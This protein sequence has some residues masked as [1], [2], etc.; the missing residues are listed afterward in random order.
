MEPINNEELDTWIAEVELANEKIKK[1]KENQISV[2]EFDKQ[3]QTR[4]QHKQKVEE[5][6]KKEEEL[7]R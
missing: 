3:E 4:Q 5:N 1:L 7:M 2:E 6:K